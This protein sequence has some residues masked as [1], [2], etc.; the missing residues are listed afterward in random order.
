MTKVYKLRGTGE[1]LTGNMLSSIPGEEVPYRAEIRPI[2]LG[3]YAESVSDARRRLTAIDELGEPY[4]LACFSL[5]AAA[6][7]DFVE[8]DRPKHCRGIVQLAD[9]KRHR[10]QISNRGVNGGNWGIAGE[11][12][13]DALQCYSYSIPDDPI[14][15]C[16][17]N[18]GGRQIAVSLTG[19]PQPIGQWWNLAY[20]WQ[21]VWK[22]AVDGRHV[23][24]GHER[25]AGENHTYLELAREAVQGLI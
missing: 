8:F 4:V 5:G 25:P 3:S 12:Y 2:G 23:A 11:R 1:S 17:G 6:G 13:I 10:R 7:G 18:N 19:L 14:S 16:P 20:T 15:A 24:Y 9:P 22:Y 21:W